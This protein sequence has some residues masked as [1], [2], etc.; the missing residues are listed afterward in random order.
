MKKLLLGLGIA[1]LIFLLVLIVLV[2]AL[3]KLVDTQTFR[4]QITEQVRERTGQELTVTGD[5]SISV[6]PWLGIRTGEIRLSQPPSVGL[7]EPLL[8]S[9]QRADV[10]V[11]FLP[12][13]QKKIEISEIIFDSPSINFIETKNGSTSLDGIEQLTQSQSQEQTE[14]AEQN[15][16]SSESTSGFAPAA[17]VIAGVTISNGE[18]TF[19]NRALGERHRIENLQLTVGNLLGGSE[20]Q[21]TLSADVFAHEQEPMTVAL[22]SAVQLDLDTQS[23]S[24]SDTNASVE[25]ALANAKLRIDNLN[26]DAKMLGASGIVINID[27]ADLLP[28]ALNPELAISR[29]AYDLANKTSENIAFSLSEPKSDLNATG[30]ISVDLSGDVPLFK[31]KFAVNELVPSKLIELMAIDYQAASKDVLKTL[32]LSSNFGGSNNGVVLK[33]LMMQLDQTQIEADLALVNF[34]NPRYNFL[35]KLD[36]INL[37][38][39]IPPTQ[40]PA[41]SDNTENAE[42]LALLLPVEIFKSIKTNGTFYAGLIQAA[43]VK[44]QE[45]NLAI[46]S[47]DNTVNIQPKATLYDGSVG[48][49]INYRAVSAEQS[50]IDISPSLKDVQFGN[51]LN[52]AGIT[53]QIAGRGSLDI[54]IQVVDRQGQQSNQ[55]TI[56]FNIKD[57]AL[58]NIDIQKSLYDAQDSIDKLKGKTPRTRP[59]DANET[60]FAEATGSFKLNDFVLTNNDLLVK[61]PLFRVNGQGSVD[62]ETQ[63]LDYLVKVAIVETSQG[64]GGKALEDLKG[65]AVPLSIKGS[66]TEPKTSVDVKQLI[67]ANTQKDVD[68]EIEKKKEAVNQVIEE[69]KQEVEE[70]KDEIVE[71]AKKKLL[72]KLFN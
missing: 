39:Y 51:L 68:Q 49:E 36:Q 32:T 25:Q 26:V 37:D 21:M 54:D 61:A 23:L 20:E 11:K 7:E 56:G 19:D 30:S 72:D 40:E 44:L 1:A 9:V 62:I 5:L 14:Q 12:L 67:A 59:A 43:G 29:V 18:F 58:K 2:I 15:T 41:A 16:P 6:F 4:D 69:K 8:L 55:G 31:G 45:L 50:I 34:E 46:A 28:T 35:V 42:P 17:I 48:G 13:L 33:E 53:D 24:L 60:R 3:P 63:A 66:F 57:G 65:F 52:D 71:D 64:Q 47:T 38:D 27:T 70:K 22:D 10:G